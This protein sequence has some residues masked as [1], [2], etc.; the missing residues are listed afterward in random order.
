MPD[1][2]KWSAGPIQ[3]SLLV[4]FFFCV[5]VRPGEAAEDVE[6]EICTFEFQSSAAQPGQVQW[7]PQASQDRT[8]MYGY[9]S[10][11]DKHEPP[12]RMTT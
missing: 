8:K 1:A 6:Q 7:E 3:T 9:Q 12:R 11:V 10:K 4:L 2:S 5:Y